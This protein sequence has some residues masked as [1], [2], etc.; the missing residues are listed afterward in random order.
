MSKQWTKRLRAAVICALACGLGATS[1]Q[2]AGPAI[3]ARISDGSEP[4]AAWFLPTSELN[5]CDTRRLGAYFDFG[6][7]RVST[8]ESYTVFNAQRGHYGLD[9]NIALY[10]G[11][12][13]PADLPRNR[14]ALFKGSSELNLQAGTDYR[15]VVQQPCT[16]SGQ[17]IFGFGNHPYAIGI[18]PVATDSAGMASGGGLRP[19]PGYM[20]GVFDGS[21]PSVDLGSGN[22]WYRV[23]GPVRVAKT[24]LY[25][26]MDVLRSLVIGIYDAPFDPDNPG[27]HRTVGSAFIQN[28][29]Y[30][31]AGR[32]YYVVVQ[33]QSEN[34]EGRWL[35]TM[36]AARDFSLNP[37]MNGSWFNPD[38]RGQ[39]FFV[40]VL[41]ELSESSSGTLFLGWDTYDVIGPADPDEA[42]V[43]YS[44]SRWL[45]AVGP[46][47]GASAELAIELTTGGRFLDPQPVTQDTAYGTI[48]LVFQ[49]C[50]N[51]MLTYDIPSAG[52]AGQMRITR[53]ANG[54]QSL[55]ASR[56]IGYPG[57][58]LTD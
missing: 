12:F 19:L 18:V 6:I 21:E 15:I 45:T 31:S 58:L 27:D 22:R 49:D 32:D 26:L 14:V 29:F 40:D 34:T 57:A 1:L 8:T 39:G 28:S 36:A 5:R 3:Y 10:S 13:V 11:D 24:G 41:A 16:Y 35:F 25:F 44:G 9:L 51:G 38:F 47:N 55:C 23:N 42:T 37:G 53:I 4:K 20:H 56:L 33:P 17:T 30:L 46:Y 43:G 52:V 50:E 48:H 7:F 54:N 2:A